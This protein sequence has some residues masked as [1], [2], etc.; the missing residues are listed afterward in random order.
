MKTFIAVL[1]MIFYLGIFGLLGWVQYTYPLPSSVHR[2]IQLMLVAGGG[3]LWAFIGGFIVY[4]TLK[5]ATEK[6]PAS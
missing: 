2:L 4:H 3:L 1:V 5:W 6:A